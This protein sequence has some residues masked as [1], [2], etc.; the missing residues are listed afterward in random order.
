[1][2]FVKAIKKH[3]IKKAKYFP[4]TNGSEPQQMKGW[5]ASNA[6]VRKIQ[7]TIIKSLSMIQF[8]LQK[9][10][11]FSSLIFNSGKSF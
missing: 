4:C 8:H 6:L 3:N 10:L 11:L 7:E 2:S 1:M 5:N 9:F